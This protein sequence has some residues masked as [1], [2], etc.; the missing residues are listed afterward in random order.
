MHPDIWQ[1]HESTNHISIDRGIKMLITDSPVTQVSTQLDFSAS[2]EE[3]N[4]LLCAAVVSKSFRSMLVANPEI[5]AKTGYQG[6][7]FN[8][9]DED[10]CWLSSVRPTSLVDFAA[11]LVNYQQNGQEN[12]VT[13]PMEPVPQYVRVN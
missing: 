11:N 2:N 3:L 5:A 7:T 12:R 4:R 13:L 6:E 10:R 9:S 8:L 1:I